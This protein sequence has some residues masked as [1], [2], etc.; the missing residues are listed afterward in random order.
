MTIDTRTLEVRKSAS[1][2]D[3]AKGTVTWTVTVKDTA[4]L[5][6]YVLH[7]VWNGNALAAADMTGGSFTLAFTDEHGYADPV[8]TIAG[9]PD[10]YVFPASSAPGAYVFTYTT[11]MNT[12]LAMAVALYRKVQHI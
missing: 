11:P 5:D 7:D 12:A 10:G 4:P 6:G 3:L 9:T 8:Q 2:P 1:E